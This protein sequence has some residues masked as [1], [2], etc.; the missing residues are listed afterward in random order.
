MQWL[1][2]RHPL[3]MPAHERGLEAVESRLVAQKSLDV[4]LGEEAQEVVACDVVR[5]CDRECDGTHHINP[6]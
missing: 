1:Q 4:S 3:Q 5:S 6:T 2:A